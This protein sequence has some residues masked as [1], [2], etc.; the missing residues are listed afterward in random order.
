MV[1]NRCDFEIHIMGEDAGGA[2]V[3][4]H[5]VLQRSAYSISLC[6]IVSAVYVCE[7]GLARDSGRPTAH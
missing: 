7:N 5:S 2:V 6:H 4:P 3:E 1:M